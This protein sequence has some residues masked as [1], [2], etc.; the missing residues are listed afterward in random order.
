V[1]QL[2]FTRL[3]G[4]EHEDEAAAALAD[5][6][7]PA[8]ALLRAA[9]A[10]TGADVANPLEH[11][12][13]GGPVI[14]VNR[15][16]LE[17]FN[18]MW[19]AERRLGIGEPRAALPHMRAALAAIQKARAAERIYLRGRPPKIVLDINRIRLQGK[20]DGIDPTRRAP[21]PS[22]V[23]PALAHRAR[24]HAALELLSRDPAA[25]VDS[26]VLVRVDALAEL[27]RLAAALDAAIADLRSGRDATAALR[28]AWRALVGEP[29][30]GRASRWSGA[31]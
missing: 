28:V 9:S 14:G 8:E 22:A 30:S 15:P 4:E 29:S 1:G 11:E 27:P 3:T 5:T 21:G 23:A 13:E 26:L 6:V 20:Q 2:I 18:A 10:A 16:L 19:E 12:E 17:A 24:F 25:A 7:S 31:W